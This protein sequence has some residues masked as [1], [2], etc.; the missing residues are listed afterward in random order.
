[1]DRAGT[2][3]LVDVFLDDGDVRVLAGD[4]IVVM[5]GMDAGSVDAVVC[6]PPYALEFM[7]RGWDKFTPAE[8][9]AWCSEWG[10]QALRVMKPGGH[11]LAFGGTRTFHRLTAGLE[12]AG[13]E[14]RDC[15]SWLYGSGF[16]K[17]LD[18][19]KAIDKAAG[20]EREVVGHYESPEGTTGWNGQASRSVYS[21][22][23]QHAD[24]E[25][26]AITAPA[27]PAAQ[28]WEG[29]GTALKP[30]WEP[31]V[32]ARKPL[33]KT[34][35]HNVQQ[36]GTGALNIDGCRVGTHGYSQEE[37][38]AKGA[39][40]TTGT[41][42]GTHRP[43]DTPLPAGRWPANV[44]L[45]EAAAQ[46][47]DAQTGDLHHQD[48]ATR[49]SKS[50]ATGVTAFTTRTGSPE[51]GDRGGPS[52]FFY[53]AK[54]SRRERTAGGRVE[55]THPTVKPVELM[56]WL[57]RLVCPPGGV[58]LDPFAGSGTTGVACRA[59]GVRCVLVEREAEYLPII[60][61]RLT[62]LSLGV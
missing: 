8:F 6:D 34:V 9:Q 42:Y 16:P 47:L 40:R 56:R 32:L 33:T 55:N 43:S 50:T 10:T 23:S 41:T 5:A 46:A 3:R 20:A 26:R 35:A 48:P 29:W 59:E 57:V 53:T 4:C 60:A 45:D 19:S 7:G 38:T 17:S 11:L 54:A 37:W 39:S 15:L 30:A 1:M 18:V 49:A 21:G 27:T 44:V 13:F 52:R 25:R 2:L 28:E 14:I 51:Y 62:E 61:G 58:V 22:P 31:I 12:D 24:G 36:H